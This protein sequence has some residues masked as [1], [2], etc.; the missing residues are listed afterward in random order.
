M[1]TNSTREGNSDCVYVEDLDDNTVQR[2][3]QPQ[4]RTFSWDSA[5][6]LY[7]S[8]D[9]YEILS[10]KSECSSFLKDN[11]SQYNSCDLLIIVDM[12]QNQDLVNRSELYIF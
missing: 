5:S 12:Q 8:T 3:P 6:H 11:L 4:C 9:K 1:F 7:D 10:L 2:H